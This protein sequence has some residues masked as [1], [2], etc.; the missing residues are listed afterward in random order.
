MS[1]NNSLKKVPYG[2]DYNPEQWP[3][4]VWEEDMRLFKK[5]GID[6]VTLNVFSWA[7]LQPSED[8]YDFDKLEKIVKLVTDN[9]MNI[10]MATSTAAHPAWMAK[11]YPDV[12]RTDYEGRKRKFGGRHNSCPNSPTYRKYSARLASRLADKF[13]NQ[14]NIIAWHISNEYGGECHCERCE[15]A[16][17]KWVQEKYKT[18]YNVNKAWNTSFWGHTFYDFDEIVTPNA[19]SEEFMMGYRPHTDFQGISLDY[20][21]F[22]SDSILE[23][24]CIERDEVKKVI[25][26]AYVTTNLMEFYKPLDYAKW[27][28]EMDFV[29]WDSYPQPDYTPQKTAMGHDLMRGIGD[30]KPFALMEQTPSVTNWQPYNALKRPGVMRLLSYQ[31]MAHGADTVLFFQMRRSIGAC[32]KYHGAVIDH[33]GTSE[34]R[35]FREVSELGRELKELGKKTIGM[36]TKSDVAVMFDWDNWW[37]V[38]YSAG[39]SNDLYYRD[40]ITKYYEAIR[41]M[42]INVDIIS[43]DSD[44]SKYKVVIAPV[45]YMIKSDLDQRIRSFVENGGS[46][47]TTFFSGYVQE[48][49]LVI[50]GGYPGKLRDIL[51]IWVEETDAYPEG[52]NNSFSYHGRRYPA[53]TLCDLIHLEGAK[54]LDDYGYLEDFYQGMPVVTSKKLGGG[55]AYYVATESDM[56]FY[57][58]F[59]SDVLSKAGV[60]KVMYTSGDVEVTSREDEDRKMLYILNHGDGEGIYELPEDGVELISGIELAS[61]M[62]RIAA[63]DVHVIEIKK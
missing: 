59:L 42:N 54:M 62:H 19:L 8:E 38:E 32:E 56:D 63:K 11:R 40:Q 55:R 51:G 37:S 7:S 5:A 15:E 50:T 16:F 22:M 6:T 4:E 44:L 52:K 21:R 61:G 57:S 26:D 31:A 60:H 3:E 25:P 12:L 10:I 47:V 14:K 24:Y 20:R 34:T 35:V 36:T 45:L 39:P 1:W 2:G 28:K 30:G 46:F 58:A 49:D 17:R 53:K 13:K 9:D 33:V 29:S 18:I 27:A 43:Q 48:N 41:K 23:C